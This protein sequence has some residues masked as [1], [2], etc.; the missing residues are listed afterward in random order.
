ME[1]DLSPDGITELLPRHVSC[2]ALRR[3]RRE[4]GP[5]SV[6]FDAVRYTNKL[7]RTLEPKGRNAL[8]LGEE[9]RMQAHEGPYT[10]RQAYSTHSMSRT[11]RAH[12]PE[13]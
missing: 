11:W 10:G 1:L 6:F 13:T 12:S 8:K 4:G 3:E 9:S 2:N 5:G 7:L